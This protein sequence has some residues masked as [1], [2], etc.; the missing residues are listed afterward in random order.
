[1]SIHTITIRDKEC[2]LL[3]EKALFF[4]ESSMLVIS[5]LH[6]G[7][8]G[9]F[10][11]KG[12]PLPQSGLLATLQNLERL[13]KETSPESLL[14]LGDLFHTRDDS[15][16]QHFTEIVQQF[17]VEGNCLL[18]K[19]NHDV[20][21]AEKYEHAG[22][23]VTDAWIWNELLFT[24]EPA[25]N[26]DG[27]LINVA[28]HVHPAV[29]VKGRGKQR[30]RLPCF[31]VGQQGILLPSFGHFT[32]SKTIIPGKNDQIFVIADGKVIAME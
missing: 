30:L 11:K 6:I 3:P 31:Y 9:Y 25:E 14:F 19:G 10:R 22:I 23:R 27:R 24:H 1:M 26:N 12:I 21:P 8:L 15:L 4:P 17:A 32:G 2:W 20:F 29:L 16:W 5:D 28:G 18:V 7:K 13:L